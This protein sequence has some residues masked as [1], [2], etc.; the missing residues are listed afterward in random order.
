MTFFEAAAASSSGLTLMIE[1]PVEAAA[2]FSESSAG[3]FSALGLAGR[4]CG[5]FGRRHHHF[6]GDAERPV[7]QRDRTGGGEQ[8]ERGEAGPKRSR[9]SN[10][11]RV[12]GRLVPFSFCPS[13]RS[14]S[15]GRGNWFTL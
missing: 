12:C 13:G 8:A 11:R 5:N 4:G 1:G 15:L 14:I 3:A 10:R 2:S 9:P 6:G 7:A